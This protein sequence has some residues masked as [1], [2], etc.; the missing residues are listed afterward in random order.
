MSKRKS[1]GQRVVALLVAQVTLLV[2]LVPVRSANA[3]TA[4]GMEVYIS[5]SVADLVKDNVS[6][7][8]EP[9]LLGCDTYSY[10]FRATRGKVTNIKSSN[11]KVAFVD[12]DP[13]PKGGFMSIYVKKPGTAKLTFTYRGKKRTA[14]IKVIEYSN[15]I[16]ALAIGGKKVKVGPLKKKSKLMFKGKLAKKTISVKAKGNWKVVSIYDTHADKWIKNNAKLSTYCCSCMIKMQ[17][18]NTGRIE[19][20]YI[21]EV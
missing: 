6:L 7:T 11:T 19:M 12:P 5:G 8:Y 9:F 2:M 20:I 17:N 18:K 4:G 13:V 14:K 16:K 3:V 15:P 1:L 21:D 10:Y